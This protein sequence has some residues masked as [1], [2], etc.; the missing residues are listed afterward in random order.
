MAARSP[1]MRGHLPS[2]SV[3]SSTTGTAIGASSPDSQVPQAHWRRPPTG[4]CMDRPHVS[5]RTVGIAAPHPGRSASEG[6]RD[7]RRVLIH[8]TGKDPRVATL[9]PEKAA[10]VA[11]LEGDETAGPAR[12]GHDHSIAAYVEYRRLFPDARSAFPLGHFPCHSAW[13]IQGK[14]K[15]LHRLPGLRVNEG[16]GV[17]ETLRFGVGETER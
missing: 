14:V 16:D 15:S 2:S 9:R 11:F 7:A 17:G 3:T 5:H 10:S 8:V 4:T 13:T 12:D 6:L 1:S